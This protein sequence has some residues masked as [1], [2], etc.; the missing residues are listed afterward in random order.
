MAKRSCLAMASVLAGLLAAAPLCAAAVGATG[1]TMTMEAT[2]YGLTA[3]DNYPYGAT[4]YFGQPLA[5]GDIAVDPS[6]IP[7]GTC[8]YVSGYSSPYLPPG[9]FIGEA[10][11]T[12]GA[13]N[14]LHID[15]FENLG[16][17][18]QISAF[19]IQHVRVTIL[20]KSPDAPSQASGTA[21]CTTYANGAGQ[22][23]HG[24]GQA[25]S[26]GSGA[27]SGSGGSGGGMNAGSRGSAASAPSAQ[28]V[29]A[30]DQAVVKEALA[31]VGRPF[32]WGGTTPAGFDCSGLAQWLFNRVGVQLPRLSGQQ[33]RATAR[34]ARA[35]LEPGDLVFFQTYKPG[36]SDVGIYIGAHG[37][38]Q[39]AFVAAD[40]RR[41]G[42]EVD[43][44]DSAKWTRLYYGAGRVTPSSRRG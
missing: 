42:V 26:G 13:I 4:D 5:V 6:V 3:Q 16:S 44:L 14:G 30:F 32:V 27:G 35:Q 17:E 38:I 1:R 28:A 11:D 23:S 9:G 33:Y 29:G 24:A 21:A 7:L 19:G 15:I 39:H 43:N 31:Q 40:N 2:A 20:G 36:P 8:L 10:D 22:P 12:G 34:I 18:S 41:V 25:G 37:G